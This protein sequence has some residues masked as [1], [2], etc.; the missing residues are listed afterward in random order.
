[1]KTRMCIGLTVAI[2]VATGSAVVARAE[3]VH[4]EC[5]GSGTN[6]GG[7]ISIDTTWTCAGSPY[8]VTSS[9]I[10]RNGAT[11]TLEPCVCV[12]F[13]ANMGVTVGHATGGAGTLVARGTAEL[14]IIFTTNDPYE[15]YPLPPDPERANPGDWVRIYFTDQARDAQFDEFGQYLSGSVL[16]YVVVEYSGS[17]GAAITGVNCSP[18][19]A[20]CEVHDNARDGMWVEPS[21]AGAVK[22]EYCRVHDHTNGRGIGVRAGAFPV[23]IEY[24]EIARCS[25][26]SH[27]GGIYLDGGTNHIVRHNVV[28]DCAASGSDYL[29]GG[30]I[31]VNARTTLEGNTV[32]GCRAWVGGGVILWENSDGSQL[33]DNVVTQ[34]TAT[35]WQYH[36]IG[37]GGGGIHVYGS[38]NCTLAGNTVTNNTASHAGGGISLYESGSSTLDANTVR[39]NSTWGAEGRG[40]GGGIYL[41]NS[42]NSILTVNTVTGNSTLGSTSHGGGIGL[43]NSPNCLL[44]SNR[45]SGNRT[46]GQN[47]HGGGIYMN[48][49]STGTGMR[50]KGLWGNTVSNNVT[51]GTSAD[52]GGIMLDGSPNTHLES[53]TITENSGRWSGGLEFWNSGQWILKS[54]VITDNAARFNAG[55]IYIGQSGCP[56]TDARCRMTD[57]VIARNHTNGDSGGIYV[58]NSPRL[59]FAGDPLTCTYNCICD[60]DGYC[61]YNNTAFDPA[62]S[63][64]IDA[65]H[66]IW[67]TDDPQDIQDCLYDYFDDARLGEV[68]WDPF[69]PGD[70]DVFEW[71]AWRDLSVPELSYRPEVSKVISIQISPPVG[72]TTINLEDK[73]PTGWAVSA[74]SHGGVWETSTGKVKWG[75]L[76]SPFPT[77]V[78]YTVTPPPDADG[79]VCFGGTIS[80]DG[81]NLG[82]CGHKCIDK[83][84]CPYIPADVP[85]DYCAGCEGCGCATCEDGR[86]EMCEMGGYACAW[87][88]DCNDDLA[89]M[90]RA[91]YIWKG[92]ECYCWDE[93]AANWF[94]TPC[95]AP[96]SGCCAEG[97]GQ[98]MLASTGGTAIRQF[99]ASGAVRDLPYVYSAGVSFDVT[100]TINP[101]DGTLA[102]ALE[103]RPPP[104]WTIGSGSDGCEWA[105]ISA[106]V[107][108]G[109]YFEPNIPSEVHYTVTPPENGSRE[110][111]FTGTVSFDGNNQPIVGDTFVPVA[112]YADC[113]TGPSGGP[114]GPPCG[115]LDYDLD[116]DVDLKDVA[117][118]QRTF[119]AP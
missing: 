19:L 101:P 55:G 25:V 99:G 10:V 69:V 111:C 89:G 50:E 100:I 117:E 17:G 116:S 14:P 103:D 61:V 31:F 1:M 90:T 65:R 38:G 41:G 44:K 118:F 42:G 80:I 36:W 112:H 39:G 37:V 48:T 75:P 22:I 11:L 66:V 45:I 7:P 102:A 77:E 87:K 107:K 76:F 109:P 113:M 98:T 92:G 57:N 79:E 86:V 73:P 9:V 52:G 97:E 29:Y 23:R 108:C 56:A 82:I 32:S 3:P 35:G 81:G 84:Q 2:V 51:T 40:T 13:K 119:C 62:G 104:G 15:V 78:H 115:A 12:R 27:G 43:W 114:Y 85:Q 70:C 105:P 110:G 106:K 72:A 54:N 64:D 18:Y 6:V 59:S 53:N 26:N 33:R 94:L 20:H 4:P 30:G 16:E 68:I 5:V 46:S 63:G 49:S 93:S 21:G 60:N 8:V 71:H 83:W 95:P 96:E 24:C 47:A 67:C 34:N 74:I 88:K 58:Y 28:E 91:A